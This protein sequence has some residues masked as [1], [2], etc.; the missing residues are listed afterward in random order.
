MT[1]EDGTGDSKFVVVMVQ[2]EDDP[3]AGGA[4]N[5]RGHGVGESREGR[6]EDRCRGTPDCGQNEVEKIAKGVKHMKDE[7]ECN[8]ESK[9]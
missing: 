8:E 7:D 9:L 3:A 1:E 2:W 4:T 6:I 5:V